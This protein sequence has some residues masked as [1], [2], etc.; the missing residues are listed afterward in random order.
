MRIVLDGKN[1]LFWHERLSSFCLWGASVTSAD[2]GSTA[3]GF[4]SRLF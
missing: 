2:W 4:L 3:K 1:C